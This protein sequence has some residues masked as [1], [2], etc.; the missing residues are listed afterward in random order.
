MVFLCEDCLFTGD[1]L[2]CGSM[3]RTDFPGGDVT[4]M[5]DS[6]RRLG[7]LTGDFTVYPGHDRPTTLEAERRSNPYLREAMAR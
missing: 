6:L 2:F 4:E 1:T 5:L 3:G 7:E